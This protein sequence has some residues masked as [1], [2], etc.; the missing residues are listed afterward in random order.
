MQYNEIQ[1]KLSKKLGKDAVDKGS[2]CC[3]F[4]QYIH[5]GSMY[6]QALNL[7]DSRLVINTNNIG[8]ALTRDHKP[9]KIDEK[10]RIERLGGKIKLEKNDVD[11]RIKGISVSRSFGDI[12]A[13][14]YIDHIPES[15]IKKVTYADKFL[16]L[17]CD[18]LWDV[19]SPQ[20][21]VDYVLSKMKYDV[22]GKLIL[23]KDINIARSLAKYAIVEKKSTDNVTIIFIFLN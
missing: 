3:A 13:K 5:E 4:I 7:G 21:A 18:G 10:N 17:A 1:D 8:F 9:E 20:E 2:T 23:K 19:V 14:P 15:V 22:K 12:V 11:W 16:I 6:I